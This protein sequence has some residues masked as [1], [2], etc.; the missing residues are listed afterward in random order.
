MSQQPATF[1]LWRNTLLVLLLCLPLNA[2]FVFTNPPPFI[3]GP[4]NQSND[5]AYNINSILEIS[6]K[7]SQSV[8]SDKVSIDLWQAVPNSTAE[9]VFQNISGRQSYNWHVKT[10]KNLSLS[11]RFFFLMYVD[12][13]EN[14]VA[15]SHQF[16]INDNSTNTTSSDET[17]S[18]TSTGLSSGAKIGIGVGVGVGVPAIAG[19]ALL[20][21]LRRR[22]RGQIKASGQEFKST[23][24]KPS[25]TEPFEAPGT[26]SEIT[27]ELGGETSGKR[28]LELAPNTVN[29]TTEPQELEAPV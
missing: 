16:I 18:S 21:I 6:W 14:Y 9:W 2:L 19:V 28:P 29:K 12:G 24:G 11:D 1:S 22:Q 7:G 23:D 17:S 13:N 10:S 26:K 25:V 27:A 20:F 15:R 3:N 4:E 5:P 8:Q